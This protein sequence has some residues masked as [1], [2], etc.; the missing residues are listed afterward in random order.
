MTRISKNLGFT[1]P[2]AMA[3]EFE[4]LAQEEQSTKSELF[5]RMFRLYQSY[6]TPIKKRFEVTEEWVERLIAEAQEEER[7][8]PISDE[9]FMGAIKRTQSQGAKRLKAL[10]I[11]SE[12][13]L[14]E[15]LYAERKTA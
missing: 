12:E 2:P 10:G 5:R 9:E 3:E 6:R 11:T 13:Q 14:D 7:R 1:V 15:M 4:Q 8:N